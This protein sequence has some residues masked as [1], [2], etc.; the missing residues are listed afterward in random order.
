MWFKFLKSEKLDKISSYFFEIKDG[1][2]YFNKRKISLEE[3]YLF[4][5]IYKRYEHYIVS[6]Y[7][8]KKES[9]SAIFLNIAF[10]KEELEKF[11]KTVKPYRKFAAQPWSDYNTLR[12]LFLCKDGI[13]FDGREIFYHEI[14]KI[15]WESATRYSYVLISKILTLYIFLKNGEEIKKV[16]YN[17]KGALYAKILYLL[18]YL[19]NKKLDVF[20]ANRVVAKPYF[21]ILYELDKNGCESVW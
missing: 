11:L 18:R 2:I 3:S 9:I 19:D 7:Q 6:L 20:I 5:K 12:T 8:E 4:F 21:K 13:V 15:D 10:N 14:K 16:Y 1:Y 17:P